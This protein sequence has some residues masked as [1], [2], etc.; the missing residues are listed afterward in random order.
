MCVPQSA[1]HSAKNQLI[2]FYY[3]FFK[4]NFELLN[5]NSLFFI[6]TVDLRN[7]LCAYLTCSKINE[8]PKYMVCLT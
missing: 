7:N 4:L 6:K 5:F 2:G 3:C 8:L 1:T